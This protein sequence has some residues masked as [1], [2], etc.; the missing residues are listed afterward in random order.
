VVI[1]GSKSD[2][3]DL[4]QT[5]GEDHDQ[6]RARQPTGEEAGGP[7]SRLGGNGSMREQGQRNGPL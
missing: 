7:H 6:A 1:K 5:R 2:K 3:T 4:G